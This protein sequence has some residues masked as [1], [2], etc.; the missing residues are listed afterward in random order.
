M[1]SF[2]VIKA[3]ARRKIGTGEATRVWHVPWL[4]DEENGYV[5]TNMQEPLRD[6]NVRGLMDGT[7]RMRD[8][9]VIDD[10]FNTRDVALIKRIPIPMTDKHDSWFW[11][12]DDTGK[13]THFIWRIC[14]GCLPIANALMIKRVMQSNRCPWC[15]SA[16]ETD[17]HVLFNCD[18][19]RTVWS[20]AGLQQVVRTEMHNTA[21][22]V[23]LRLFERVGVGDQFLRKPMAG[24]IK[25]NTDVAVFPDGSVGVGCVLRDEQG[26]FLGARN[27]KIVGA[28][29]PRE[30][31]ALE[32]NEALSWL[33]QKNSVLH[34]RNRFTGIG[35]CM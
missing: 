13:V 6:I 2:E 20:M 30:A 23:F 1:E 14:K 28:W 21:F 18:F 22:E 29:S 24:W 32:M 25:I 5:T 9:D 19:A 26:F 34:C 12:L 35:G 8:Y 15:W 31:E 10:L 33:K 7:G 16:A 17:N 27:N 11:L 4:P 3:G